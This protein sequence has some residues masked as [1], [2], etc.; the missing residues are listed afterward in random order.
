MKNLGRYES[1]RHPL[2]LSGNTRMLLELMKSHLL[3]GMPR[4]VTFGNSEVVPVHIFTDGSLEG[5]DSIGMVAGIGAVLVDE[6]G[7]CVK[8]F[9]YVPQDYSDV[10]LIGGKIHQ[11][12]ILPVVMSCIAFADEINS[13]CVFIHVDNTAAQS[14][15]INAGSTNHTSRSLV[16]LYLDLEQRLQFVPW[17]SR[18]S[19]A[20]N[21][22]DGPSRDSFDEV[23]ALGAEC[24]YFP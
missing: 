22:A 18:V 16:Y 23:S 7:R 1:S 2:R 9:S 15:L 6:L 11:L 13:N 5:D 24:F 12:E 19:S 8:A 3:V 14:S 21:I 17:V 20:S 4:R 10:E